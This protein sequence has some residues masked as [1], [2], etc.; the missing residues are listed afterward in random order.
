M[1]S[2][3]RAPRIQLP[4]RRFSWPLLLLLASVGVT[5]VAAFN[6]QRAVWSHQRTASRLLRDYASFTAWTSQ[7]QVEKGLD[8][9]VMASLQYIM[10]GREMHTFQ[11]N[12][13]RPNAD[14]LWRYYNGND[15][16]R[17]RFCTPK[18]CPESFPPS[19][20]FGFSLG[21][22]TL[23]VAPRVAT[24]EADAWLE[25][26]PEADKRWLVDSL[27][28]HVRTIHDPN[29]N[30]E[31]LV[32]PRFGTGRMIAYALM[33]TEAGDTVVYGVEFGAKVSQHI[34]RDAVVHEHLLPNALMAGKENEDLLGLRIVGARSLPLFESPRWPETPYVGS[35]QLAEHFGGLMVQTA[36]RPE[37]ANQLVIGGLPR[38]RLPLLIGMFVVS[39]ALALVAVTL[40]RREEELARLRSDFVS[41]VS[42]ELRTP[43]AQIRLFIETL[44]L[45]R[46]STE[47][48]RQWSLDNI[49]RE[50]NRLAHLVENV[51]YFAR[52]GRAPATGT[53]AVSTDLGTEIAQIARAF[54][55]LA[56]SR[57]AA[58]K[59]DLAPNVMVPLQR[60]AFRQVMLN[61]LDNAVKY[62]PAG[63]TITIS[64]TPIGSAA[65]VT[66]ADEGPGI[67]AKER[68]AIWTPFFRG[69]AAGAQGAGG[70]GIGLAIVKDIIAQMG[71]RIEVAEAESGGAAF[72]VDIPMAQRAMPASAPVDAALTL[73]PS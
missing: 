47:E 24:P 17:T 35:L 26:A 16:F 66:V 39:L 33:P 69:D 2:P 58:L 20:Y 53:L 13:P 28:T 56:A 5:A 73:H 9:A 34:F 6:A 27:T 12:G 72:F 3:D 60:E 29:E 59:L 42:H 50:T 22:D 25:V 46:F 1:P 36:V 37:Y 44:R 14:D 38:S 8:G 63:Q 7:R 15:R 23:R 4:G 30:Y 19:A 40:L 31:V 43:L 62:G 18:R 70:S 68:E 48:Q 64:L 55:P 32:S 51:L 54:E 67:P 52:A 49:D 65:R 61:L 21:A 41:S 57:R 71:A 45:G 10:H 11:R